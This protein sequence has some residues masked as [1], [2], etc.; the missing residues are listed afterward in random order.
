MKEELEVE[1]GQVT[2]PEES[3]L[4]GITQVLEYYDLRPAQI[5][6]YLHLAKSGPQSAFQI[7]QKVGLHRT[8]GHK[9]TRELEVLG[10]VARSMEWP[11]K[12]TALSFRS[13]VRM[14]WEEKK[15]ALDSVQLVSEALV[16]AFE[17]MPMS[18][19]DEKANPLI[20]TRH[21]TGLF[22]QKIEEYALTSSTRLYYL[23][24]GA[25]RH[26]EQYIDGPAAANTCYPELGSF[27][28]FDRAVFLLRRNQLDE[29]GAAEI[30]VPEI[31]AAYAELYRLLEAED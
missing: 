9:I 17:K 16:T 25:R 19:Q 4:S 1:A 11:A 6:V 18:P 26:L 29:W 27:I 24:D 3:V 2:V 12:Y 20:F 28:V 21:S 8:E 30:H 13:A 22:R 5:R 10:L 15:R 31:V 23:E 7:A 14:L